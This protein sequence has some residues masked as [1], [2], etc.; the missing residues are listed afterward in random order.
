[1]SRVLFD[2]NKLLYQALFH[3]SWMLMAALFCDRADGL[4][5]LGEHTELDHSG[6]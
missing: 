1:M 5:V 3:I 6:H 2:R 4:M